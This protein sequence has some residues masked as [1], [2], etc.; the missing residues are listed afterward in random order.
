MVQRP[1]R[2]RYRR[3]RALRAK[4]SVT[5]L[6][7]GAG[8]RGWA[9]RVVAFAG[10]ALGRRTLGSSLPSARLLQRWELGWQDVRPIPDEERDVV[11]NPN[12]V[13]A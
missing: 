10:A 7:A 9:G 8:R 3:R 5:T 2:N 12:L 6:V 11:M 4:W 13:P 1:G